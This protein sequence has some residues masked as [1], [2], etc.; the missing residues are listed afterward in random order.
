MPSRGRDVACRR[1]H[2]T[3][4]RADEP[5]LGGDDGSFGEKARRLKRPSGNENKTPRSPRTSSRPCTEAFGATKTASSVD[6]AASASRALNASTC[7]STTSSGISHQAV[8]PVGCR[9]RILALRDGLLTI[10]G[11]R[12]HGPALSRDSKTE[13]GEGP[14]CCFGRKAVAGQAQFPH[15]IR[16]AN[17]IGEAP[18]GSSWSTTTS[19]PPGGSARAAFAHGSTSPTPLRPVRLRLG[20]RDHRALPRGAGPGRGSGRPQNHDDPAP[21][22]ERGVLGL[23]LS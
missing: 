6:G 15:S 10:G 2:D 5:A 16:S 1:K 21:R 17:H 3:G 13:R 22:Q 18:A 11:E 7:R 19:A 12:R 14:D 8:P 20:T 9:A 4:V 23:R